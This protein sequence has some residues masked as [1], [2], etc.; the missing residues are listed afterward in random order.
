MFMLQTEKPAEAFHFAVS[1]VVIYVGITFKGLH[2]GA[3]ITLN[4]YSY[5]AAL[6]AA[7]TKKPYI[8]GIK[9]ILTVCD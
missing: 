5:L 2:S 3:N 9:M 4:N 7:L 8:Y 6:I 1:P